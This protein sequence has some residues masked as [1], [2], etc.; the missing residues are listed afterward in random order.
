MSKSLMGLYKTHK[1]AVEQ[2]AGINIFKL[3]SNK[4]QFKLCRYES[5]GRPAVSSKCAG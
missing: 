4:P 3:P 2:R 1:Q 5:P